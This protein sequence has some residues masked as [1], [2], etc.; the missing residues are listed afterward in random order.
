[1][2]NRMKRLK[3]DNYDKAVRRFGQE[4]EKTLQ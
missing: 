2:K 4:T 1:M 3:N